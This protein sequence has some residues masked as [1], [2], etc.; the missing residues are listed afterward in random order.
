MPRSADLG[1]DARPTRELERYAG[2]RWGGPSMAII[3]YGPGG[4]HPPGPALSL[5][6]T[7]MIVTKDGQEAN[8]KAAALNDRLLPQHLADLRKSGLSDEQIERCGFHSLQNAVSVQKA[9]RW[10]HYHGEL[11]DCLAIPFCDADGKGLDYCRLKPDRPR[12]AKKDGKPIKYESPK[13]VSNRA[14]FPPNT[15]AALQN[16]SI[17]LLITEGEKKSA[18]ADQEGFAC[19][20]LVGVYGWQKKRSKDKAVN[21]RG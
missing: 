11:G 5:A 9:L 1:S 3:D 16:P 17:P 20:G 8:G 10:R 2:P 14:Y 15:L 6:S 13:G 21:R 19:I 4:R 7:D 18:K 12:R